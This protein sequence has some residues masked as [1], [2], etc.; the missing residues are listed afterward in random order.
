MASS[1][2][3]LGFMRR[4]NRGRIGCVE[5]SPFSDRRFWV[6]QLMVAGVLLIKL[7]GDF[8]EHRA[9]TPI[10]DFVWALLLLIPVVYTGTVFGLVGSLSTALTGIVVLAPSELFLPHTDIERWGT[11]SILA[12]VVVTA[13]LLGDRHEKVRDLARKQTTVETLAKS[14]ERFRLAFDDNVAGMALVDLDLSVL[15]VNR[16]LCEMLGYSQEELVGRSIAEF[17]HLDDRLLTAE[18]NDRLV[19]GE[20]D[21]LYHSKRLLRKSG[22]VVFTEVSRTLARD[23][24]GNPSFVLGSIRDITKE[25]IL[26]SRL[27]HQALHDP[28][29]GLPNRV[30]LQDRM[31]LARYKA[32]YHLRSRALLLL[33][34]DDFKRVNDTFGHHVGDQLLVSLAHR[35]KEIIRPSDTLYRFGGDEFIYLAE[36]LD[37]LAD[38]EGIAK[39]LLDAFAEPFVVEGIAID[40][41]ASI[42][43]VECEPDSDKDCDEVLRAADTAMYEAKKQ[44]KSRYVLFAQEMGEQLSR[45]FKL[46]QDLKQANSFGELE[47]YYQPIVNLGTGMVAGYEALMRWQHPK[48][49][50]VPPDVFIPI[51]EESDLILKLGSFALGEACRAAA[52]WRAVDSGTRPPYVAVNVSIRQ[53]HDPKLLSTVEEALASS[54]LA[55]Q[56]LVIEITESVALSDFTTAATVIGQFKQLG[57]AVALDD[58]GTGYSS[59]SYLAT[60]RPKIIKIDRSFVSPALAN[61][62]AKQLLRAIVLFCHGLDIVALAEG[63]ETQEQLHFLLTLGCQFG[64]G[65]LFSPAVPANH[66]SLTERRYPLIPTTEDVGVFKTI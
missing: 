11:W 18:E 31:P 34:L 17:T 13:V 21:Q 66:L 59:L 1:T 44:G 47:M 33:D 15:R 19:L 39:L 10:P 16:S 27:S 40:Q 48:H 51:A 52:S 46:A 42:G 32:A 45:R 41:S 54:G 65:Y 30:L 28:L 12:M 60:L 38:A 37:N 55:P 22:E 57:V 62:H 5:R 35:L 25:R 63:I 43:V 20:V 26:A 64:Q 7:A 50:S 14:E 2:P 53:F 56:R 24:M 4:S 6:S 23:E 58:F 36:E 9:I 3:V 8:A 29:T 61:F 49:G